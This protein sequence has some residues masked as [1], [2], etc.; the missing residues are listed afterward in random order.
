MI[1][2]LQKE[3]QDYKIL[4]RNIPSLTVSLFV[5]SVVT[6][7]LMANKEI[8]TGLSWLALDCGF[9]VSWLSFLTMDII[10]KR[11][12]AKASIKLSLMAV[13][14][15]L[16]TCSILFVISKIPGNWGEFYT[17][18]DE[19]INIALN[20]TF[21]G[22]WYIV[23]GSMIA[24]IVS[25]ITNSILNSLIGKLVNNDSF[26]GYAA[27]TYISTAI[28]QF[29]DN[30]VFALIVSHNFFGWSMLQCIMCSFAGAV[31]ELLCEVI[32]SPIGY[33]VCRDW[34]ADEVGKPYIDSLKG[35][36]V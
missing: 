6:M 15:N 11:F 31:V 2:F 20:N 33:K 28:G 9:L 36:L 32:F 16:L 23:M 5:V 27:R 10:T 29:V 34:E 24:F 13:A 3:I 12:G 17:Y 19:T 18:G 4:L 30:F 21:G 14:I 26:R 25:S 1:K 22:T 35:E 7:N 8:A